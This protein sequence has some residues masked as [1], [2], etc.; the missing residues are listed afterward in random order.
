MGLDIW[1]ASHLKFRQDLPPQEEIEKWERELWENEEKDLSDVAHIIYPNGEYHEARLEGTKPGIYDY[2]EQTKMHSFRGGSYS[3]Y[4]WWRRHLCQ[5]ALDEDPE[6]V[7]ADAEYYEGKPF[8]EIIDFSDCEGHIG[9]KVSAKLAKDFRE[10]SDK[11]AEYATTI[12]D[13]EGEYWLATYMEFL[14]AFELAAQNG[15]VQF[16]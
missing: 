9:T 10:H 11:A 3:G 15:V 5:F 4:N 1:A 16:G 2:T 13:G 6:D 8:Y 7:W 12:P 14:E